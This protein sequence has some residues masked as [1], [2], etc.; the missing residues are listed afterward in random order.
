MNSEEIENLDNEVALQ[1]PPEEEEIHNKT[2]LEDKIAT[3]K[4]YDDI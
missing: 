4:E 3:P 1:Q 2:Q